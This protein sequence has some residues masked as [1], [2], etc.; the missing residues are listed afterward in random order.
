MLATLMALKL[1]RLPVYMPEN[2]KVFR[3]T[4]NFYVTSTLWSKLPR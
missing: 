1:I 3:D 2:M 4:R